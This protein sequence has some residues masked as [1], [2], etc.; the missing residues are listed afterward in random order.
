V[1]T[2]AISTASPARQSRRRRSHPGNRQK[3]PQLAGFCH[4]TRVSSLQNLPNPRP[5]FRKSP[6]ATGN[7]PVFGRLTPETGFDRQWVARAAVKFTVF[8]TSG[9]ALL[10]AA[11]HALPPEGR[12]ATDRLLRERLSVVDLGCVLRESYRSV[13][14]DDSQDVKIKKLKRGIRR[15]PRSS[16]SSNTSR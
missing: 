14:N 11:S 16:R 12:V 9:A 10:G 6:D 2:G 13:A 8:F 3:G 7:I 15:W 5:I 4:L 1:E